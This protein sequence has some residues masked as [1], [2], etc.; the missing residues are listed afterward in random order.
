MA[1]VIEGDV[2]LSNCKNLVRLKD[3][4]E[5]K[6]N[7]N[8][9]GC[10]KFKDLSELEKVGHL[11]LRYTSI[12]NLGALEYVGCSLYLQNTQIED[13]GKLESV[14]RNLDLRN[15]PLDN[16]GK[17]EKVNGSIILSKDSKITEEYVNKYKPELLS[18][19]MWNGYN[20]I[21]FFNKKIQNISYRNGYN[22]I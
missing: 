20:E 6:G 21:I 11:D 2:N 1:V 3:I 4:T 7:L 18:K 12:K 10:S 13:L 5:I 15:T 16:L 9:Y 14:G 22:F 8:L 17:L 19:C